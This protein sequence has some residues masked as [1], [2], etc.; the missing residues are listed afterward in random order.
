PV[1]PRVRIVAEQSSNSLLV[2]AKPLDLIT[3][4]QMLKTVIDV[5]PGDSK[6]VMKPFFIGPL[7]YAVATEVVLILKEVYRE[8]TNQ[9]ASQGLSGGFGLPFGGPF[10]GG[11]LFGGR[12]Q[13]LD[14]LGRPKQVSLS[15]TAD[16][17]TNSIVGMATELMAKDIGKVVEVLEEKA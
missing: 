2:R 1:E 6:A 14:A 12:Q 7:Q 17:R 13:P 4:R 11:G 3:I 8:S 5:G 16:D 9:A 10:G 15:I